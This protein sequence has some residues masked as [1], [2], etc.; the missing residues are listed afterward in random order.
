MSFSNHTYDFFPTVFEKYWKVFL[1]PNLESLTIF[2]ATMDSWDHRSGLDRKR[3]ASNLQSIAAHQ[4]RTSLRRLCLWNCEMD[5]TTLG[6]LLKLPRH[7]DEL[8]LHCTA[9]S[10]DTVRT[11]L[12]EESV[13]AALSPVAFSL[14]SL[15]FIQDAVERVPWC[16]F[17]ALRY[18]RVHPHPFFGEL[19]ENT[20][21]SL[22]QAMPPALTELVLP[23]CRLS[24]THWMLEDAWT[25]FA[26]WLV[27]PAN[28]GALR[29]VR[30]HV[31]DQRRMPRRVLG[32]FEKA[33]VELVVERE[34]SQ[35]RL[36]WQRVSS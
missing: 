30:I 11:P 15:T 17:P 36:E 5:I 8:V 28:R 31:H 12:T 7:L 20:H 26:E 27:H 21:E 35:A 10:S 33:G 32:A 1:L 6:H 13:L 24:D 23:C 22:R 29:T 2:S 3:H 19:E 4:G 18:L 9:S 25:F 34:Y 16:H 14:R